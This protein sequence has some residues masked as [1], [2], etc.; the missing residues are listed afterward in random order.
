MHNEY[1]VELIK[2]EFLDSLSELLEHYV[3]ELPEF[4]EGGVVE[5]QTACAAS[6]GFSHDLLRGAVTL[7]VSHSDCMEHF[8]AP[9]GSESSDWIGELSN[10][11]VGRFKN[12][13]VAYGP[14]LELA[15]PSVICGKD[16]MHC[17]QD[18]VA[19]WSTSWF[20]FQITAFLNLELEEGLCLDSEDQLSVAD[21]GSLCFF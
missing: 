8:G 19:H 14:L 2:N 1:E 3:G 18:E 9:E 4:V 13:V 15:L 17:C 10:Q 16:L 7:M 5:K 12:K 11:L 20:G 6:V 21:E